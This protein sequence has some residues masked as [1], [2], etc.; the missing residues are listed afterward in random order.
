MAAPGAL[1][2]QWEQE[3]RS[4]QGSERAIE[5][6][7]AQLLKPPPVWHSPPAGVLVW[8]GVSDRIRCHV[9]YHSPA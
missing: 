9:A 8:P 3:A 5:T 1:L 2:A 4:V 6:Y 7:R